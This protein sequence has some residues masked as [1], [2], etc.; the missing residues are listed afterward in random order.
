MSKAAKSKLVIGD[1]G[2]ITVELDGCTVRIVVGV[3]FGKDVLE[4]CEF[5]FRSDFETD[6]IAAAVGCAVAEA[7]RKTPAC[8]VT[9]QDIEQE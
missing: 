8:G 4:L 9:A 5:T 3:D 1:R 2:R 6:S 7:I